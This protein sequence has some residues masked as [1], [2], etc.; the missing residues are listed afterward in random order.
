MVEN[1]YRFLMMMKLCL[2]ML[3]PRFIE[4]TG[5]RF[6]FRYFLNSRFNLTNQSATMS[7]QYFFIL[8]H[9]QRCLCERADQCLW[10][11][12]SG[13]IRMHQGLYVSILF[14][15]NCSQI[16]YLVMRD[17]KS[18]QFFQKLT[19]LELRIVNKSIDL[20]SHSICLDN[21]IV[22]DTVKKAFV[23][24]RKREFSV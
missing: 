9:W 7:I 17:T 24:S 2:Q 20:R 3:K 16:K 4:C 18:G 14:S 13:N 11:I 10:R 19:G 5:P 21:H 22:L 8:L 23:F 1:I 15:R 12:C 6:V